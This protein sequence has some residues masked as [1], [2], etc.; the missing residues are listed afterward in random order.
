MNRRRQAHAAAAGICAA[1]AYLAGAKLSEARPVKG[2]GLALLALAAL[3]SAQAGVTARSTRQRLD[4]L[5][6]GS[7]DLTLTGL[8]LN[9]NLNMSGN[10]ITNLDE[11][12]PDGTDWATHGGLSFIGSPTNHGIWLH[13]NNAYAQG[14]SWT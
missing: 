13:G 7:L 12:N 10:N 11:I 4:S 3:M 5:M 2:G 14:G 6:D 8:T 9:G 1:V